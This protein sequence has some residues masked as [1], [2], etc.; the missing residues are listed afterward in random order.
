MFEVAD[1]EGRA[2]TTDERHYAEELLERAEQ[3]GSAQKRIDEIGRAIGPA[4]G[5]NELLRLDALD[6]PA[7]IP[8]GGAGDRFI[9]SDGY[10]SLFGPGASRGETWSTGMIEVTDGPPMQFK[11][12]L[13]E[14]GAISGGQPFVSVPQLLPGAVVQLFQPL[15]FE[16]LLSSRPVD[17][18][19]LRYIVEGTATN[20][21]AGVAEARSEARID[22]W[23]D[24]HRRADQEGRNVD[25]PDRRDDGGCP[26][27]PA[28][29]ER[30]LEP[31]CAAG[32][33]ERAVPWRVRR[34][35]RPGAP[36]IEVSAD[37]HGRHDG[38]QGRPVVQGREQHA[39][40]GVC[41]T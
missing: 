16:S 13:G 30:A 5:G 12:T 27:D 24:V 10:K 19:T 35:D 11:G 25:H 14:S 17:G 26:R 4:G 22:T 6:S 3:H 39:R 29:R 36:H 40:L 28:I 2:L 38:R 34:L 41:R 20:A 32:D 18:P 7:H 23:L 15:S 9:N 1:R 37:L 31:V 21:A 33:R 8:S